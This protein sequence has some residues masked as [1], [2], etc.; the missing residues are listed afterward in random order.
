MTT[1]SEDTQGLKHCSGILSSLKYNTE[2]NS[3]VYIINITTCI[4]TGIFAILAVV[5]N[6]IV[7][8]VIVRKPSLRTPPNLLLC[9]VALSDLLTAL[10]AQ[11]GYI[12][13]KFSALNH[14]WELVCVG[15]FLYVAGGFALVGNSFL[16]LTAISVEKWIA[17]HFHLRYQELV[18]VK[19]VLIWIAF[20][21]LSCL[22]S[23]IVLVL[24]R[25][26][27]FATIV[28]TTGAVGFA[29]NVITY[30]S[31]FK[32]VKRHENQIHSQLQ[33]AQHMRNP[34]NI[35]NLPK[36]GKS[37]KAIFFVYNL[38]LLCA[39]PSVG[40]MIIY[41]IQGFTI[42]VKMAINLAS[43]LSLYLESKGNP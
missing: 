30:C 43:T 1:I 15:R 41:T 29:I 38:F 2:I 18:T 17:L 31:I 34:D 26:N 10:A 36:I 33:A 3:A 39:L 27:E 12:L 11:P 23:L 40:A 16:S 9:S 7:I 4:L 32:T 14:R 28:I 42:K 25:G 13:T 21:W 24:A 5:G 22:S 19:G 35:L 37:T 20:A 8:A 6:I